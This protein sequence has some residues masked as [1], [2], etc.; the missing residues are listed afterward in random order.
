MERTWD[1][2][3]L[4]AELPDLPEAGK[5]RILSKILK[6]LI[7]KN[8]LLKLSYQI[9]ASRKSAGVVLGCTNFTQTIK[10]LSKL[11]CCTSLKDYSPLCELFSILYFTSVK[12]E[13]LHSHTPTDLHSN[14]PLPESQCLFGVRNSASL[15]LTTRIWKHLP[16]W[17]IRGMHWIWKLFT[18]C[19]NYMSKFVGRQGIFSYISIWKNI[20]QQ[21][22]SLKTSD[23]YW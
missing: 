1:T 17:E 6:L 15:P 3:T 9:T 8:I 19:K 7:K 2:E 12:Q 18:T 5:N 14:I 21:L 16:R 11:L 20:F 22:F 10:F 23:Y 4:F 13:S